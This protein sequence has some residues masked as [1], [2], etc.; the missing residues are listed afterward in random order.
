MKQQFLPTTVQEPPEILMDD[1]IDVAIVKLMSSYKGY[2]TDEVYSLLREKVHD[3]EAIR[4]TMLALYTHGWFDTRTVIG[5]TT[6]Y[7]LRR[8]RTLESLQADSKR[9]TKIR[10]YK[11]QETPVIDPAGKIMLSDGIDVAIWKVMQDK[12]WRTARDIVALV[13]EFGFDRHAVDRRLDALIRN[14]R[15]FD[16]TGSGATRCYRL[17]ADVKCP[18]PEKVSTEPRLLEMPSTEEPQEQMTA[19]SVAVPSEKPKRVVTIESTDTLYQALAKVMGDFEEYS[20][21]DLTVLLSDYGFRYSQ[22]SPSL[23]TLYRDGYFVRREVPTVGLRHYYMYRLKKDVTLP[24]GRHARGSAKQTNN[25][26]PETKDEAMT[27]AAQQEPT[28]TLLQVAQADAV[29]LFENVIR[30]K[31][32]EITLDEFSQLYKELRAQGFGDLRKKSLGLIEARYNIKGAEFAASELDQLVDKMNST[33][34][35]FQKSFS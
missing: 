26:Q 6:I 9:P 21:N 14:N 1:D 25:P 16:R 12:R 17:K 34:R 27:N 31:G 4:P 20:V 28:G 10:K 18:T 11:P 33:A 30:I 8:W 2:T 24:I 13:R 32:I 35:G 3:P 15:M 23:S 5:D 7:T 29:P 22:I 19:P